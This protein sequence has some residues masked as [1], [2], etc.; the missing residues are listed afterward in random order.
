MAMTTEK[1]FLKSKAIQGL[2]LM[3]IPVLANLIGFEWAGED[4]AALNNLIDAGLAFIGFAWGFY[5]RMTATTDLK[6]LP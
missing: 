6:V 5:G 3:L 2:L 4:S 1:F